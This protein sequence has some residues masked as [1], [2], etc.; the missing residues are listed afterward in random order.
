MSLVLEAPPTSLSTLTRKHTAATILDAWKAGKSPQTVRSY[1]HDLAAF[2]SFLAATSGEA[3]TI[4]SG[5]EHLFRM[6]SAAAHGLVLSYRA[7]MLERNLAPASINR[8]LATLRSISKLGRML[9]LVHGGWYLEV[10]GVKGERRRDTRGPSVDEVKK[11][12]AATAADTPG[13]TRDA[14]IIV[15]L[16]CL[17]LRVS[18]LCGLRIEETDL[19]RATTWVRGKGRR[20]REL[21]PLPPARRRC[22]APVF[23]ASRRCSPGAAVLQPLPSWLEGRLGPVEHTLRAAHRQRHRAARRRA[24]LVP[25]TPAHRDHGSHHS[26]PASRHRPR[27]DSGLLAPSL[28]ANDAGVPRHP[29][30][31]RCASSTL[32]RRR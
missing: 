19:S 28:A 15:T 6:D 16:F 13:E 30:S 31:G 14:A 26:R 18:E 5:L 24:R 32:E 1:Q 3:V 4:T 8:A 9:G 17:G 27:S 7:E 11:M 25:R 22:A 29:R 23:A 20:E 21:V 10:P 2:A 12:L